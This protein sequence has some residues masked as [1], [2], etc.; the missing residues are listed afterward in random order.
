MAHIHWYNLNANRCYPF[1]SG[2]LHKDIKTNEILDCRFF[3]VNPKSTSPKVSL[4]SKEETDDSVVYTFRAYDSEDTLE[5]AF[6]VPK[7]EEWVCVWNTD[8]P[9][10]YGFI[11]AH[12]N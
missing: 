8:N 9:K 10:F 12:T 7:G 3:I 1:K 2:T 5:T 11:T 4:H 6:T